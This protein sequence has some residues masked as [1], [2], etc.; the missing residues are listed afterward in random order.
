MKES[1]NRRM[2]IAGSFLGLAGLLIIARLF[3]IQVISHNYY[4]DLASRQHVS[5]YNFKTRRG[6]IYLR[7]RDGG[8]FSAAF[9][10]SG[11]LAYIDPAKLKNPRQAYDLLIEI[12]S[13]LN[14]ED[15]FKKASKKDDPFEIISRRL[16]NETAD[17]IKKL[18][19]SG[20]GVLGEEWRFYPGRELAAHVIGF[21]GYQGD[22]IVGRY[23]VEYSQEGVLGEK[24]T[25]L[26]GRSTLAGIFLDWGKKIFPDVRPDYDLVLTVEPQVQLFFEKELDK[27]FN[28]WHAELAGGVIYDPKSGRIL[29]MAA[30]P[31]FDPNK[32]N[33]IKSLNVFVNP[34]IEHIYEL[35][36]VF[37]PLTLVSAFDAG[38]LK[39]GSVYFDS[40]FID[41]GDKRIENYDGKGRGS[42]DMQHVLNESLNTGAVFAMRRLGMDNLKKYFE[43]FGLNKKT[44]VDLPGEVAGDFSNLS[45]RREI[46]YATASFGQGIAVTPLAFLRA[47]SALANAGRLAT[48]F[49]IERIMADGAP[50]IITKPSISEPVISPESAE[51]MTRMLVKVVDEALAGGSVKNEKYSIAA[52]TGTA[53]IP[54]PGGK[55][56]S[57]DYL[58]SFFGYAP[59]YDA[60]FSVF[61]FLVKPREVRY[62]SQSLAEPF[63]EIMKFL[64][65]YYNVPPDR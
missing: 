61:L 37:K 26:E 14:P 9:T 44:G 28:K 42:V 6:N 56:Y 3:F 35:G 50:D 22:Q 38:K 63:M 62:A 20:A 60:R 29:A 25:V 27:V 7:E 32:Y 1:M 46:E 48:P 58:H 2:F 15:F 33:E 52:K 8:L 59:A 21:T 39:S 24:K 13:R 65:N 47:V 11:F 5:S 51:E 41:F 40:G 45:S 30:R 31:A 18:N 55:G 64:L 36:S 10:K 43:N 34:L 54:N 49:V 23:G 17:K 19:L 12:I 53:E 57:Q 4:Q 16:D